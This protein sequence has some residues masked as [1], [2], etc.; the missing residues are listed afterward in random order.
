MSRRAEKNGGGRGGRGGG[1]AAAAAAAY[2][3]TQRHG[4]RRKALV[5]TAW[6]D[7]ATNYNATW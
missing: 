1:G 6:H 4:L 3:G 7:G 5:R 2:D